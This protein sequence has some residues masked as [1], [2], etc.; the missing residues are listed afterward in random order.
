MRYIYYLGKIYGDIMKKL[1]FDDLGVEIGKVYTVNNVISKLSVNLKEEDD[2]LLDKIELSEEG[3]YINVIAT[4][5]KSSYTECISISSKMFEDLKNTEEY[6]LILRLCARELTNDEKNIIAMRLWL[7]DNIS[8]HKNKS[9][10]VHGMIIR[11]TSETIRYKITYMITMIMSL[12]ISAIAVYCTFAF[13][14]NK[15]TVCY[16]IISL[17]V[18]VLNRLTK[19]IYGCSELKLNKQLIKIL[20]N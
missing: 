19:F 2:I 11:F 6:K 8:V 1:C 3:G 12:V 14:P 16:M 18:F 17:V 4:N 15:N 20:H 9:L 5:G 7:R 10:D 13:E